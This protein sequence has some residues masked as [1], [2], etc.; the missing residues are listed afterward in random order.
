MKTLKRKYKVSDL[1]RKRMRKSHM[2]KHHSPET[3]AKMKLAKQ[4]RDK[5]LATL[6]ALDLAKPF[7][8]S[9]ATKAK[10]RLIAKKN[11][12]RRHKLTQTD[13]LKGAKA[14]KD[15]GADKRSEARVKFL[16]KKGMVG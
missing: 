14:Q 10:L 4:S 5:E 12:R 9:E 3:I 16:L 13:R 11:K 8:H 15:R 6:V 2:G 1:T 7:R